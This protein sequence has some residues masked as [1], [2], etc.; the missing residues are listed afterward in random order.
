MTEKKGM[1]GSRKELK[2]PFAMKRLLIL[3][4]MM[5]SL[6]IRLS[7]RA[8]WLVDYIENGTRFTLSRFQPTCAGFAAATRLHLLQ[9]RKRFLFSPQKQKKPYRIGYYSISQT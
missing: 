5:L 2:I 9:L 6:H 8:L 4:G 1:M 7:Y 3:V